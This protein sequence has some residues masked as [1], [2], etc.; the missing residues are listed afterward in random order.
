M[1]SRVGCIGWCGTALS[2]PRQPAPPL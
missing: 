2:S 1:A